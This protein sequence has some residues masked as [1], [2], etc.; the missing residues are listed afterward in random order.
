MISTTARFVYLSAVI[1]ILA[2]V[3]SGCGGPR[4]AVSGTVTV[5]GTPIENGTI[6]FDPEDGKGKGKTAAEIVG[7]K[8][9]LPA[10]RGPLPGKY[11]VEFTSQKKTGNKLP[12]GDGDQMRDETAQ[13]LPA[14]FN[15]QSTY[16][17]EIKKGTN[18]NDFDLKTK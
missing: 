13:V 2:V 10:D 1:A 18:K 7:G 3:I 9:E 12:T 16:N 5:D 4:G 17:V 14:K 11:K 6:T 8:Y 15:T